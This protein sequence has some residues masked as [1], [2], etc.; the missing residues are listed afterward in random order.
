MPVDYSGEPLDVAFNPLSFH[1]IL[2]HCQ[3]EIV[4]LSLVDP[5]TPG[6]IADADGALFVL[7]PMR[8][9]SLEPQPVEGPS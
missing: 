8:L 5:Y 9:Q 7:M 6:V 1:D 3:E 2:R 4:S